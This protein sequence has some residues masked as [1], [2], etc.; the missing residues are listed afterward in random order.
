MAFL[1]TNAPLRGTETVDLRFAPIV[2]PLLF[3]SNV[4]QPNVSFTP[5]YELNSA[6]QIMVR[7]L[8]KGNVDRTTGLNFTH[9]QTADSLI[10]IV[11]D[12]R[13]Q[14]SE[15]IY[16][17]VEV[18]R[19]SGQGAEK[20]EVAMKVVQEVW[21]EVAHTKLLAEATATVSTTATANGAAAKT[22]LIAARKQARDAKA[23]PDTL[24]CSTK[25]Y[26]N[27]LQLT[28]TEYMRNTNE[29]AFRT[30]ILGT[31]YNMNVIESEYLVDVGTL[32]SVEFVLYDHDAYSIVTQLI[33]A[34]VVDAA[35]L[36][37]GSAAQVE[38]LS[39]FKV[40]NPERVYKK[41]V[42]V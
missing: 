9:E 20:F 10:P 31:I 32:N 4:F 5:K 34:R 15:A 26:G 30:G 7:K 35:P 39:G 22:E 40:T 23:R 11:L 42:G 8:G 17:A 27:L 1:G 33:A 16:A 3:G 6:G 13:F 28:G 24:I 2:E 19:E 21:Q 37:T 36:W 41:V 12:E 38:M 25:F 14:K 29:E 18:A